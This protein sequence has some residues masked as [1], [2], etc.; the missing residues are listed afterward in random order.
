MKVEASA[1]AVVRPIRRAGNILV[2][3]HVRRTD[4]IKK[5]RLVNSYEK[6]RNSFKNSK[7]ILIID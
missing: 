7:I 4:Y 6:Y 5:V 2:G 3:I 1:R